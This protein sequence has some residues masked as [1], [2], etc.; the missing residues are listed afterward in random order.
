MREIPYGLPKVVFE[1]GE[2]RCY[3]MKE[4]VEI[5]ILRAS[6]YG[7]KRE[8]MIAYRREKTYI[9]FITIHP[10]KKGQLKNRLASGR[11]KLIH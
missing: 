10:L 2:Q 7:R 9:V 5:A 6:L 1:R 4:E 3:D 8:I 11:W